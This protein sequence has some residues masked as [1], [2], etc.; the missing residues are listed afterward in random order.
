MR[1]R[2]EKLIFFFCLLAVWQVVYM[3]K[4]WSPYLFPSP[5]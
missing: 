4:I 3:L 1:R 2:I 5:F